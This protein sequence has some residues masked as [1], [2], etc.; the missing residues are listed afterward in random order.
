MGV[1]GA[2]MVVKSMA[3]TN[4]GN[5]GDGEGQRTLSGDVYRQIISLLQLVK[6]SVAKS[7]EATALFMDELSSV[8]ATGHLDSK[9]EVSGALIP[10]MR[11][12]GIYQVNILLNLMEYSYFN[13]YQN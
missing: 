12:K 5:H 3:Y 4:P 9:V 11:N 7:P 13:K 6:T 8:I 2:I 1:I 10:L